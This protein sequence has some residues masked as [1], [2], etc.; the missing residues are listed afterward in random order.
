MIARLT[1]SILALTATPTAAPALAQ[2]AG[3]VSDDE[4]EAAVGEQVGAGAIAVGTGQFQDRQPCAGGSMAQAVQRLRERLVAPTAQPASEIPDPPRPAQATPQPY[5]LRS[6]R[7]LA[8]YADRLATERVDGHSFLEDPAVISG[9]TRAGITPDL[10][11]ILAR[12]DGAG[13]IALVDRVL[14]AR[15][16]FARHCEDVN[17]T[18]FVNADSGAAALCRYDSMRFGRAVRWYAIGGRPITLPGACPDN[19]EQAPAPARRALDL[20]T[21]FGGY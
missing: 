13:P 9:M 8:R 11:R 12:H 3:C 18:L 7:G 20:G 1:A 10:R 19:P 17:Y 6:G 4:L 2:P 21:V 16:C 15:A 14:V 5:A